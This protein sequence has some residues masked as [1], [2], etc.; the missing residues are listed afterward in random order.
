MPAHSFKPKFSNL[1]CTLNLSCWGPYSLLPFVILYARTIL[2]LHIPTHHIQH[3]KANI[4]MENR[5]SSYLVSSL[6]HCIIRLLVAIFFIH[7]CYI[8]W[9]RSIN[10]PMNPNFHLHPALPNTPVCVW[11]HV[12]LRKPKNKSPHQKGTASYRVHSTINYCK[13]FPQLAETTYGKVLKDRTGRKAHK[14]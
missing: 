6:T 1:S 12:T 7:C 4:N 14:R 3:I 13:H 8:Y 2:L 11:V 10:C 5:V 9:C